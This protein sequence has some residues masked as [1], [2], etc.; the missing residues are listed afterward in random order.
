MSI[1][2]EPLWLYPTPLRVHIS[3]KMPN[4]FHRFLDF[5][6]ELSLCSL[7]LLPT[8]PLKNLGEIY[9][10]RML[11]DHCK[12]FP[13]Q[14]SADTSRQED[15]D[16]SRWLQV[17][18]STDKRLVR[19]TWRVQLNCGR[20][21]MFSEVQLSDPLCICDIFVIRI[22]RVF[23]MCLPPLVQCPKE[24]GWRKVFFVREQL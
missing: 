1:S 5:S 7:L 6:Q 2:W 8:L 9:R 22:F 11:L 16:G 24:K 21:G 10:P 17:V 20:T 15:R 23:S 3:L 13:T 12:W 18:S 19:L 14:I 4:T